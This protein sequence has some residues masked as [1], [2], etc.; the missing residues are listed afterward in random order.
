LR[1]VK[2]YD[3]SLVTVTDEVIDHIQR[4]HPEMLS[5]EGFTRE[6]LFSSILEALEKPSEVYA[7]ARR[8]RYFLRRLN[9]LSLNIVVV[10]DRVMTA[11]LM[12]ERTYARMGKLRWLRRLY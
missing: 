7:D 10:R 6:Q 8:S 9:H 1:Q 4:K 2:T 3:G 12:G 5:S 11:Y